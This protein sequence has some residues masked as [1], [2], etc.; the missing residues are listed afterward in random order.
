MNKTVISIVA[1]T[2]LLS[3]SLYAEES[4]Q[5]TSAQPA[6]A[7]SDGAYI[8]LGGGV[9]F[10]VAFLSVGNYQ[11]STTEYTTGTLSDSD[12]GYVIYGGYQ[13][14][15]IIAVEA[16]YTDYGS[17]S[18]TLD[19]IVGTETFESDPTAIALYANA[20]YTFGN[21]LRPFIQLGLS[22]L[23][24]NGS[25]STR[26]IGLDD[27][28]AMR[29]GLGL[30]Y[31]PAKLSGLGFRVAYIE[32]VSMDYNYNATNNGNDTSTLQMNVAGMLYV[33]AQYKF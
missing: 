14:N 16:S 20:G 4:V 2:L 24:I 1:G 7:K 6:T 5:E 8:G 28:L 33:G 25:S 32:D 26:A 3:G 15:K 9:S 18:D 31:A 21:G 29:F 10:N 19:K 11:D 30:E 13:F 27:S 12:V 22:Y 17:F 23:Q